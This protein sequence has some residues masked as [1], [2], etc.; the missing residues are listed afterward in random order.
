M[1]LIFIFILILSRD[2][3]L[4]LVVADIYSTDWPT[5]ALLQS[6]VTLQPVVISARTGGAAKVD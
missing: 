2:A 5:I 1:I 3:S 4:E 6:S